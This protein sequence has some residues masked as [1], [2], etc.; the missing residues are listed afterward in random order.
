MLEAQHL[1]EIEHHETAVLRAQAACEVYARR[2]FEDLALRRGGHRLFTAIKPKAFSLTDNRTIALFYLLTGEWIDQTQW[3]EEYDQ[4]VK[5]R[6]R[7]VHAGGVVGEDEAHRSLEAMEAL[8]R[9]LEGW[10]RAS[11]TD[12]DS[13]REP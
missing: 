9:Y 3:W 12:M 10:G 11:G 2:V 13:E 4:H 5:R 7:I 1:W 8:H 6:H